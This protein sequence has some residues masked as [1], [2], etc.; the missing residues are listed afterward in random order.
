MER[1]V[2]PVQGGLTLVDHPG[3]VELQAQVDLAEDTAAARYRRL[4]DYT[5]LLAGALRHDDAMSR[6][7][8]ALQQ[9]PAVQVP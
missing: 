9:A 4:R 5:C 2:N 6:L 7:E 1:D 3:P 8:L